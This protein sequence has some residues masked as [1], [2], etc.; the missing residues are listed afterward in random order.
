MVFS[1]LAFEQNF[2]ASFFFALITCYSMMP[3]EA[4]QH[5][6]VP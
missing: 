5:G 6:L 4:C 2:I 1:L 3:H